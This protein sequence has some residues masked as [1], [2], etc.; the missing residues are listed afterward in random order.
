[1]VRIM[2][3]GPMADT[4][5]RNELFA[6]MESSCKRQKIGPHVVLRPGSCGRAEHIEHFSVA[7][8]K[9]AECAAQLSHDCGGKSFRGRSGQPLAETRTARLIGMGMKTRSQSICAP[10]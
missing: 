9:R 7:A 8:L 5:A 10:V 1:M 4:A 3:L 2:R 6:A